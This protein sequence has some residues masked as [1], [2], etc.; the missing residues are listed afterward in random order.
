MLTD[1]GFIPFGPAFKAKISERIH[2]NSSPY[3]FCDCGAP[4]LMWTVKK[5][6]LRFIGSGYMETCYECQVVSSD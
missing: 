4:V 1:I 2:L 6:L 3:P 5:G